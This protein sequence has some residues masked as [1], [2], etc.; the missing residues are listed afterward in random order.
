[1]TKYLILFIVVCCFISCKSVEKI[2]VRKD[3]PAITEGRLFKNIDTAQL[4][5]NS[6]YSKKM[7]I[8][9]SRNGKRDNLKGALK[10]R[11]DSFIWMS[12]TA[13]LGIEVARVL[14]TP[15]SVKFID[16]YKKRYFFTDYQYF[17]D[18]FDLKINFSCIQKLLTNVY[19]N[20]ESC[21]RNEEKEVRFKLSQN[22]ENYVLSNIQQ[23]AISRKV[24]KYFKKKRKNKDFALFLQK[25]HI[26][27]YYFRPV[28]ISWEDLDE[29][30]GISAVYDNQKNYEGKIFPEKII[31]QV[32]F[33]ENKIELE[34]K[35]SRLEFNVKVVPNF[36]ISSK[37]KS[38]Q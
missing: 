9:I 8:S 3:L 27:P 19:F 20:L 32:F 26:D 29:D 36:R 30:M 24:R 22:G 15:D 7:D 34:L 4:E 6:L 31:F 13:P 18:R 38:I 14:L 11:R 28:K 21:S 17:D 10:I 16:S 2:A 25:I 23:K 33:D 35:F 1:M 37:Y 5:Y 12:L